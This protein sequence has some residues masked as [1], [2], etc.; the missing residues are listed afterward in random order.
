MADA[1]PD[2]YTIDRI[3]TPIGVGLFITDARWALAA[4]DWTDF[5]ERLM[6][7]FRRGAGPGAVLTSA[8]S[9]GAVRTLLERYFAGDVHAIDAV[10]C[11]V[12]GG[13]PFQ[14]K[15]WDA[16]RE[17]PVGTRTTYGKLAVRIGAPK[18]FRAVGLANNRNP[19][20]LVVPCHRVVGADGSLTGY[21]G[22]LDRKQWLLDHETRHARSATNASDVGG[23]PCQDVW[24]ASTALASATSSGDSLSMRAMSAR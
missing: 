18:A 5:E 21:A 10:K 12:P 19:I 22:G 14:R 17:I 8:R 2:R 4:Y 15:V 16:L 20:A 6:R 3:S 7:L 1:S 24:M 13:T 9:D 11:A 23:T